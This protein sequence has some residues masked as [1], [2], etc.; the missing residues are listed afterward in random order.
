MPPRLYLLEP[1][2]PGTGVIAGG[3]VRP[4][5]EAAGVQDVLTK[6]IGSTNPH[7]AVKAVFD[8]LTRLRKI[9]DVARLRNKRVSDFYDTPAAPVTEGSNG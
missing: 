2:S 7:N 4:V 5:L 6:S 1:A 3:A 8:G 9:G